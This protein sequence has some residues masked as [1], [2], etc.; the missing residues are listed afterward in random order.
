[1]TGFQTL[2]STN[3]RVKVLEAHSQKT[4]TK[5]MA[6]GPSCLANLKKEGKLLEKS[7]LWVYKGA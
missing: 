4:S 3:S 6:P 2:G 7:L 5:S 1:M